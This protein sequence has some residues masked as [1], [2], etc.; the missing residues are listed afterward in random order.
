MPHTS[1]TAF[2][3]LPV[4]PFFLMLSCAS[5]K[6][7][8]SSANA[9]HSD[10]GLKS[11]PSSVPFAAV[12]PERNGE[13]IVI[14]VVE[15]VNPKMTPNYA[16]HP[17]IRALSQAFSNYLPRRVSVETESGVEALMR[18]VHLCESQDFRGPC[19]EH[20]FAASLAKRKSAAIEARAPNSPFFEFLGKPGAQGDGVILVV[21]A[22]EAFARER[23]P[24][25]S[26]L[27]SARY[28]TP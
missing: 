2:F 10:E 1:V 13:R 6:R 3:L 4:L 14:L 23:S 9:H 22:P 8:I 26:K 21:L 12:Y 15:R 16:E 17:S 11:P 27:G 20:V 28:F 5:Q 19:S 25:D 18:R 24:L 7:P